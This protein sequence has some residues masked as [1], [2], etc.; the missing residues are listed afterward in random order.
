LEGRFEAR[1]EKPRLILVDSS[2]WIDFFR[3]TPGRAGRELRRLIS[4]AEPLALTGVVLT[5]ILQGLRRDVSQIEDYLSMWDL[6]EPSGISTYCRAAA[7]FRQARAKGIRL[8]TIDA[9]NAAIAMDHG[10][11]IFTIDKDF[12]RIALLADLALH[13]AP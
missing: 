9:L 4:E 7:L 5:E 8:T 3:S 13:P 6:L 11:V 10:A 1:A 12:S 2:V